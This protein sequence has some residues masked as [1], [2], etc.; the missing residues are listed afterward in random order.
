MLDADVDVDVSGCDLES[1]WEMCVI[2]VEIEMIVRWFLD[3]LDFKMCDWWL[4][5]GGSKNW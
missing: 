2:V 3:D 4:V 1:S 5:V